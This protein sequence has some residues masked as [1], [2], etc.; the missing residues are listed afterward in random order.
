MSF[1]SPV[2]SG[3]KGS[4]SELAEGRWEILWSLGSENRIPLEALGLLK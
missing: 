2:I 3:P 1:W 4:R